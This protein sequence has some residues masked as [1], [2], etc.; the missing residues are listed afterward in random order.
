MI[1]ENL[2]NE[3]LMLNHIASARGR[4]SF[5]KVGKFRSVQYCQIEAFPTNTTLAERILSPTE[6]NNNY[7]QHSKIYT[8]GSKTNTG[9]GYVITE[10]AEKKT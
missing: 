1:I 10:K 7:A 4:R 2:E 3:I 5:A 6:L 9:A 8:D